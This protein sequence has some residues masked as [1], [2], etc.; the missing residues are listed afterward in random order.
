MLIGL[1]AISSKVYELGLY[2]GFNYNDGMPR[3]ERLAKSLLVSK[4]N[5]SKDSQGDTPRDILVERRNAFV[6]L[7]AAQCDAMIE[8]FRDNN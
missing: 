4:L 1:N 6:Q 2:N 8:M 5:F 7:Y 3:Y